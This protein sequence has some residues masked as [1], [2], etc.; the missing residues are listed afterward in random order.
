MKNEIKK[1]TSGIT[2]IA[3]VITIIVLLI[4]AGIT[5]STLTGENGILSRAQETRMYNDYSQAEEKVRLA[6]MD[7]K[8]EI[9]TQ[10][11]IN[12]TYDAT[13]EP[14][15]GELLTKVKSNLN[16]SGW[17]NP[18]PFYEGNTIK[19]RYNS[20]SLKANGISTGIPKYDGYVDFD[21]I[22]SPQ[23][24][25]LDTNVGDG[26]NSGNA[27]TED[28]YR[29]LAT[30]SEV[31]P[32]DLFHY[33]II[34]D[35]VAS[36]K[37]ETKV[38]STDGIQLA[39]TTTPGKARI[40]GINLDYIFN[41]K[42]NENRDNW[43][44]LEESTSTGKNSEYINAMN[45]YLSKL[46]IPSEVT[47]KGKNYKITEISCLCYIMNYSDDYTGW[48]EGSNSWGNVSYLWGSDDLNFN[49]VIPEGVTDL[50]LTHDSSGGYCRIHSVEFSSDI[51]N[52]DNFFDHI[53]GLERIGI[54][55]SLSAF[56]YMSFN[57]N[58]G[59]H[60]GKVYLDSSIPV[61]EFYEGGKIASDFFLSGLDEVYV[62]LKQYDESKVAIPYDMNDG[63]STGAFEAKEVQGN[64]AKYVYNPNYYSDGNNDGS[65]NGS[66]NGD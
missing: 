35:P 26:T 21:I 6:Y 4:L 59:E 33:R 29:G 5:I 34:E 66:N 16:D 14:Y 45:Y 42:I 48:L 20:T 54:T 52:I 37:E 32:Q 13:K 10:K 55:S 57:E 50:S 43:P 58:Y 15:K 63:Y 40:V 25:T 46:V 18:E 30:S 41:Q 64:Y 49:I 7:V 22:I 65:N 1:S 19:I 31:A 62:N 11:A 24:A 47:L 39:S 56:N 23:D 2:L 51:Q 61:N 12:G 3:L 27:D 53:I 9:S 8:A 36:I 28:T 44:L 38:A 17:K 60:V